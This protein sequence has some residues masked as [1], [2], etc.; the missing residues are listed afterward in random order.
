MNDGNREQQIKLLTQ[1]KNDPDLPYLWLT[2]DH[3]FEL[4]DQIIAAG[5]IQNSRSGQCRITQTGLSELGKLQTPI[6]PS[7]ATS[8]EPAPA[9]EPVNPD[10]LKTK[11][12]SAL[13]GGAQTLRQLADTTGASSVQ[14]K[15]TLE[16]MFK[17]YEVIKPSGWAW[18]LPDHQVPQASLQLEP[19]E[20]IPATTPKPEPKLNLTQ[21]LIALL[22]DEPQTSV[23]FA[24][25][26]KARRQDISATLA[27]LAKRKIAKKHLIDGNV[28]WTRHDAVIAQQPEIKPKLTQRMQVLAA[29]TLEPESYTVIAERCG[30]DAKGVASLLTRLHDTREVKKHRTPD[31]LRWSLPEGAMAKPEVVQTTLETPE[32][33]E[34]PEAQPKPHEAL[35]SEINMPFEAL[36][37]VLNEIPLESGQWHYKDSIPALKAEILQHLEDGSSSIEWL[38]IKIHAKPGELDQ[39]LGE[40]IAEGAITKWGIEGTENIGYSAA[41]CSSLTPAEAPTS[42]ATVEIQLSDQLKV[43]AERLIQ[44]ANETPKPEID[45]RGLEQFNQDPV[46]QGLASCLAAVAALSQENGAW[47]L[48]ATYERMGYERE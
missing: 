48:E 35:E 18:A 32:P 7:P 14:V 21:R 44:T 29:L 45:P 30:V 36:G 26:L 6:K 13:A 37:D 4:V 22:S 28:T 16:R 2:R 3:G 1:V 17:H 43:T 41:H 24:V 23:D 47:V 39:A 33:L 9:L 27:S 25:K 40:L 46:L 31:G 5:Q 12:L 8:L 34:I 15:I 10:A 38:K 19:Q 20:P 42:S 11:I